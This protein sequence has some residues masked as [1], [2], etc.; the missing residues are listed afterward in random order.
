MSARTY[1]G[2]PRLDDGSTVEAGSEGAVGAQRQRRATVDLQGCSISVP[3]ENWVA[4]KAI[5]PVLFGMTHGG[6]SP[7]DVREDAEWALRAAARAVEAL[8]SE[9]RGR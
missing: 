2:H 6:D 8:R 5:A 3:S 7:E 4:V 1:Y 9:A